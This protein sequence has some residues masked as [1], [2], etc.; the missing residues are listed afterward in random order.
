M[1]TPGFDK[2]VWNKF[3]QRNAVKLAP[4]GWS[5]WTYGI[6]LYPQPIKFIK[7]KSRMDFCL[8]DLVCVNS[9]RK[10]V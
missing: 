3:E 5:T 1:R 4:K 9:N 10:E 7:Q 2:F 6:I 8:I